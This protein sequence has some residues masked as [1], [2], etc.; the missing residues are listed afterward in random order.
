MTEPAPPPLPARPDLRPGE[1]IAALLARTASA[2]HTTVRELTGLQVHSRVWEEPP[3]DLLHRVAA[4]TSTAVD[5][6]RPATL[7]GAYPGT[8]PE[9]ARTGRRYAGQPATCPQC[10]IA[11][12]AARLNIVVLCPNCGCFLHDAYFPHPNH[13]GPDIEA[14]HR[15]M[16]ATLC[17]AGESQRAQDR[18]TR[19]E[20]LMA[21]LEHALW[22]NWPPLLP[23]ES[24]LWREAVVDFLRWG[25]Q[26]GRVVARPP[27]VSATTLALTWAASATQAAARDL[28]DQIAIM[29]DPW[30]PARDM[31]PR[32]P[33][34]DTGYDAVMDLILDRGVQIEHIPT[35]IRRPGEPIVLP[36]AIRAVRTAEAVILTDMT[37]RSRETF[38]RAGNAATEH[39]ATISHRVAR[40][41]RAL[42]EDADTYPRLAT[43]LDDL[44][45]NGLAPLAERRQALRHLVTVPPSV[46][47]RLPAAAANTPEAE[48]V[49]AAWVW[50]DATLG[51]PAGGPHPLKGARALLTFDED[52]NPEGRLT[53]RDWWQHHL[54]EA[55][56]AT[57]TT[58][59]PSAPAKVTQH[60]V[61]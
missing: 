16:L 34:A 31:V 27:Y 20:S 50:L 32:W 41:V 51:R 46:I 3:D 21:G 6:L 10:Q 55:A 58:H 14:V 13:P 47:K 44:T 49:A 12:V 24:T 35:I 11:T 38:T 18:L 57:A 19:L 54:E 33:D 30:L 26:P 5:E 61:S 60:D 17:S 9:R 8:A 28:A 45:E 43:Y 39:A 42:T 29:G 2:N 4:L 22:T 40:L 56:T 1:D 15:E 23:G 59:A 36:E 48:T 37:A 25:L 7:R 53:L 52:L